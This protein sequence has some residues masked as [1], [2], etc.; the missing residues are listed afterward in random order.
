M[1][2]HDNLNRMHEHAH[3]HSIGYGKYTIIWVSLLALTAVTVAV[4]GIDLGEFTLFVAM[5][6]ATIKAMIVINVFMHIKFDDKL[7]KGF[8]I[9][10]FAIMLIVFI[11]LGFDVFSRI[12]VY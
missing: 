2:G 10:C 6:V 12:G 5:L 4:A 3:E 9:A 1:S 8:V 11:L 7:I